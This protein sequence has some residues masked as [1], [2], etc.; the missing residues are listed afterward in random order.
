MKS[1]EKVLFTHDKR[2]F[3]FSIEFFVI[4]NCVDAA[5]AQLQGKFYYDENWILYLRKKTSKAFFDEQ[6]K[7]KKLK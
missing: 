4:R 3:G 2:Y 5:A 7:E 6:K 1:N